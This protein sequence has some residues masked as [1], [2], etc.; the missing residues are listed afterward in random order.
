LEDLNNT[1][2]FKPNNAFI[3]K[4]C[5]DIKI[6]WRTINEPWRTFTTLIF[7]NQT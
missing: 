3:L 2:V 1:N 4:S 7:L 5:G 6:C